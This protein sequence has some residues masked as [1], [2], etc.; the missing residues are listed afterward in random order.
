MT[1]YVF[2]CRAVIKKIFNVLDYSLDFIEENGSVF[3]YIG[4]VFVYHFD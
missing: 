2:I 3:Q 1:F 4:I